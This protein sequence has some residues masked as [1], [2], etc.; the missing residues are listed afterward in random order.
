MEIFQEFFLEEVGLKSRTCEW[1]GILW[2][3]PERKGFQAEDQLVQ[4]PCGRKCVGG[5]GLI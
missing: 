1:E 4:G 5:V 3:N 2:A